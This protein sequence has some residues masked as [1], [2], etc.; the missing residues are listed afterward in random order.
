M[1]RKQRVGV[2]VSD[3]MDKTVVVRVE[4][5]VTHPH[6]HKVLTRRKRF[7]A[8]DETNVCRLGDT[9]VI[10][11]CRPLSKDKHWRV[12]EIAGRHAVAEIQPTEI[13]APEGL[14]GA[15]G[16]AAGEDAS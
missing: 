10:E 6:Y 4:R 2:V 12:L 15:A 8:H 7:K 11:E 13:G 3:K 9:V 1:A 5:T 14:G 16:S